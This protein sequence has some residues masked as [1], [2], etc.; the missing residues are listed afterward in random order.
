MKVR[1]LGVSLKIFM[2]IIAL[3]VVSD[4]SIGI[5]VYHQSKTIMVNQ[6][7]ESAMNIDAC[8]AAS[9]DGSLLKSIQ[10]G[11]EDTPAFRQVLDT[12]SL[13]RDYSGVEYVYTIRKSGDN[14]TE[15]VV[16]SDP[17][18]PGEL[19]SE[20]EELSEE[21]K[22]AY[23]GN[24][25]VDSE[26][27]TDE[28]GTHISA[29]SPI[30]DGKEVV[31]LA[32]VDVSVDQVNEQTGKIAL[33]I[34]SI[35]VFILVLGI[36]LL[37]FIS[38]RLKAGFTTLDNKV[39]ELV[40]GNGDLTKKINITTGDEFEAIGGHV[41]Q[42]LQFI[43]GILI[44]IS[45]DSAS[46]QKISRSITENMAGARADV[47]DVSATLEELTASMEEV[48]SSTN[49]V[50]ELIAQ[51]TDSFQKMGGTLREG[52][53]FSHSMNSD[54]RQIG[55]R[56]TKEQEE[57]RRKLDDLARDMK[58]SIENSKAVDQI[59]IL[60][61]SIIEITSQTDLLSLNA[62]IEA[63]RAGESG[64][65]FAVVASEIGQLAQRS[66]AAAAEIQAVSST[67][68]AAVATLAE[69]AGKMV[70]FVNETTLKGYGD[71]VETSN[72]YRCGAEK[73]DEMMRQCTKISDDVQKNVQQ[74]LRYTESVN[75]ATSDAAQ[76]VSGATERAV[77]MA[78][79]FTRV[80]DEARESKECSNRLTK[81]VG[82]FKL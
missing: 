69:E 42:L 50:V 15:F 16:D 66:A 48:A 62:S 10:P 45:G 73:M 64:R 80:E 51:V 25:T 19:G 7:K 8:V 57:A 72:A 54:A 12:L 52:S 18:E 29:Y 38:S 3:L 41:N 81:E 82:N 46:L 75:H 20:F 1:K 47:D 4:F 61:D 13:F 39:V 6:I 40:N 44:R 78:S 49:Q 24:T 28:W 32:V 58:K 43:Q 68:I 33:M 34:I 76:A 79:R 35:C 53:D 17:E 63:A 5:L 37:L 59:Q 60:T 30:Y 55:Q 36:V 67:V 21:H 26:P 70:N 27:Y 31:G 74:A 2:A 56:A 23:A 14:M 65:G 9:V 11:D 71:L 22:G 77:D